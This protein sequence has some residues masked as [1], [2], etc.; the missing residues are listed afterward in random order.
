LTRIDTRVIARKGCTSAK[1][2]GYR[3]SDITPNPFHM[4]G[5]QQVGSLKL[6][7]L[8]N[9]FVTSIERMEEDSPQE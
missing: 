4:P 8:G 7:S 9:G 2:V 5:Q 6:P 3:F 1:K